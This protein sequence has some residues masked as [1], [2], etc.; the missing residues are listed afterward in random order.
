MS[1]LTCHSRV[2]G[3]KKRTRTR[4][5]SVSSSAPH[6]RPRRLSR[7]RRQP[8]PHC[9][10][11]WWHLANS[12]IIHCTPC[13][14]KHSNVSK[15]NLLYFQQYICTKLP[16]HYIYHE[17]EQCRLHTDS[18]T[19]HARVVL[20]FVG[21]LAGEVCCN[22]VSAPDLGLGLV[23]DTAHNPLLVSLSGQGFVLRGVEVVDLEDRGFLVHPPF[24][25]ALLLGQH[26]FVFRLKECQLK[27]YVTG[28]SLSK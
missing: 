26:H 18:T 28:H 10:R 3:H 13:T 21:Q 19:A 9:W 4:V 5:G 2:A 14:A 20:L 16:L 15:L 23:R 7:C 8:P 6:S 25:G 1:R 12:L 17:D 11:Y 22:R 24:L 27:V